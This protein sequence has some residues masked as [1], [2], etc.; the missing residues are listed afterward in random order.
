MASII[1]VLIIGI[2]IGVIIKPT[3]KIKKIISNFQF[4]GVMLLLFSM[5]AGLG[6]N[7]QLLNNLKDIG[8]YGF[9]FAALT[10]LFSILVVYL[11]TSVYE[12]TKR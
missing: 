2:I 11:T 3:E 12:R 1:F 6:L 4:I 7:D 8:W 9:A 5:G 10:T